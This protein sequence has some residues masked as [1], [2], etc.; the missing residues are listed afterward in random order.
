M[1]SGSSDYWTKL[2]LMI[3]L[4]MIFLESIKTTEGNRTWHV[5]ALIPVLSFR[6]QPRSLRRHTT[7]QSK[8]TCSATTLAIIVQEEGG[9]T[10]TTRRITDN[11]KVTRSVTSPRGWLES[12]M[13]GAYTVIR[14][15]FVKGAWKTWGLD[16]HL[17]RLREAYSVMEI[18]DQIRTNNMTRQEHLEY[19]TTKTVALL[20]RLFDTALTE[21][22][23]ETQKHQDSIIMI[24]ILWSP[25][26][27]A[28]SCRIQG[29]ACPGMRIFGT[30]ET[31]FISYDPEPLIAAVAF[32]LLCVN[33]LPNRHPHPRAKLS[34][35]CSQR[36]P[37][38]ERFQRQ[39]LLNVANSAKAVPVVV[40]E[41]LLTNRCSDGSIHLLEGLTSNLFVVYPDNV[42]RTSGDM[43]LPGYARH[44]V[45][46]AVAGDDATWTIDLNTPIHLDETDQW[47][48]V[49]VTSAIR[50]IVPVSR[51]FAPVNRSGKVS[52][53][54]QEVWRMA[55][56]RQA[57]PMVWKRL[58][59]IIVKD[60]YKHIAEDRT[61]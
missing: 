10:V 14:C 20:G 29:H 60:Q 54:L 15:D 53:T 16:F 45:L 5:D 34:I 46:E 40:N 36:R 59:N 44:L 39:A 13:S 57:L 18:I 48:E 25:V 47:Q 41:V 32:D 30:N 52:A 26:M 7:S 55:D 22:E 2:E 27:G 33:G 4:W 31:P 49:F 24:T 21:F 1:K 28:N 8:T 23:L 6:H 3:F 43:I 9:A 38:E 51:I 58:Y 35:W 17:Q 42:I 11:D 37:L 56:C 50:I 19:A 61:F 12:E